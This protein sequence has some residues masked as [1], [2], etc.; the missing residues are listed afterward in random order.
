MLGADWDV[1][2]TPLVEKSIR[3]ARK[4]GIIGPQHQK[5]I[6]FP[7]PGSP[8]VF[9][10]FLMSVSLWLCQHQC[11]YL[12]HLQGCFPGDLKENSDDN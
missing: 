11:F 12:S 5:N 6:N 3:R 7:V 10:K 8:S 4:K 2:I 9:D 1:G